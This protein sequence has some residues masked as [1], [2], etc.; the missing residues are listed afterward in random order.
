MQR[1]DLSRTHRLKTFAAKATLVAR[2]VRAH[3]TTPDSIE[4]T[5]RNL[6]YVA[7][8]GE[9]AGKVVLVTGAGQGVG[10]VLAGAL[11][12]AGARVALMGRNLAPLEHAK[13]RLIAQ[14]AVVQVVVGDASDPEAAERALA[15]IDARLGGVDIL[16]NN[17]GVGGPW[18]KPFWEADPRAFREAI[19]IN[20]SGA[21]L[22][23]RAAARLAVAQNRPLRIINVS[24]LATEMP[25]AG[26]AAYNSSKSGLESLTRAMAADGDGHGITVVT[27]SLHS[28]QTE[29]KAAHDWASNALL[30]PAPVVVPAFLHVATA[31]AAEVQGRVVAS[32]RYLAAPEAETLLAGPKSLLVPI[33]Y[34][35]FLHQGQATARDPLRFSIHDRAENPW[36]PSPEALQAIDRSLQA[37]PLSHYPDERLSELTGMLAHLH[38][39]PEA[40]FAFGPGSWEVL[41]R[42]VSLF[43]KPGEQVVSHDPGWFGFNLVCRRAGVTQARA[44]FHL[45]DAQSPPSQNLR[46]ILD[47]ITPQT[48]LVYLINPANPEGTPLLQAEMDEFLD[49]LPPRLPVIIDEAY[50]EYAAASGIFD[51]VAAVKLRRNAIIGLRTFSKFYGLAGARVGYAYAAP[52]LAQ[53]VRNTENIFSLSSPSAAAAA[54]A[55]ADRAYYAALHAR[56]INERK[57]VFQG[58]E[59]RGLA[60]L[61]AETPFVLAHRPQNAEELFERLENEGIYIARYAFHGDRYMM[62]PVAQAATTEAIFH[63]LDALASG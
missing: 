26:M 3:F 56:F 18:G 20:L 33:A 34:P 31:P 4:T 8:E 36:G 32:W 58:L 30:P 42:L 24:S 17:A 12:E 38:G 49:A 11:A 51:T 1:V 6:P 57:T 46:A 15:E 43:A 40:S 13:Q 59:Q 60:P 9:L 19:D 63:H 47:R 2:R 29:R 14:G 21:F 61:P 52:D 10:L 44:R 45:G 23:A 27:L 39:L 35:P 41:A 55:L 7:N 5:I 25:G 53:L 48:R 54:A 50:I 22:M 62:Y 28:V 16:V 37:A